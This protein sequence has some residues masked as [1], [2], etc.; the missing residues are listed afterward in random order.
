MLSFKRIVAEY[1]PYPIWRVETVIVAP[2]GLNKEQGFKISHQLA[3]TD[4]GPP[5]KEDQEHHFIYSILLENTS[6]KI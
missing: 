3:E 6:L 1:W 2:S 5:N 4:S